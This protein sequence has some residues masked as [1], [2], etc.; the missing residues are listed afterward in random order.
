MNFNR[1]P[2]IDTSTEVSHRSRFCVLLH[3]IDLSRRS[4]RP[5]DKLDAPRKRSFLVRKEKLV[6]WA[7]A[8][9]TIGFVDSTRFHLSR[10]YFVEPFHARLYDRF[11]G[12]PSV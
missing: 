6:S 12:R 11:K 5:I 8:L 7:T 1:P 4:D 2:R 9:L 3:P 10:F